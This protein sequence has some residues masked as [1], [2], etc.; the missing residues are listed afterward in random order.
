MSYCSL[1]SERLKKKNVQTNIQKERVSRA[2]KMVQFQKEIE[3]YREQG[4]LLYKDMV[5][6]NVT[7]SEYE[8]LKKKYR[9]KQE[10]AKSSW[11]N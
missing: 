1:S 6:G 8:N 3:E 10:D 11:K 4:A 2:D 9:R 7:F 5:E